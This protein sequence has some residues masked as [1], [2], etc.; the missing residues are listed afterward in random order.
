MADKSTAEELARKQDDY[1][2]ED[3]DNLDEIEKVILQC[4]RVRRALS[5]RHQRR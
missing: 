2:D 4:L 1:N 5:L 3:D